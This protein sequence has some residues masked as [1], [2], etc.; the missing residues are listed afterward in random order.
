MRDTGYMVHDSRYRIH[1]ARSENPKFEYRHPK[2]FGQLTILSQVEG[3]I[4][5]SNVLNNP[6]PQPSPRR[7]EEARMI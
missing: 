3:Q 5:I 6:S 7:G 2:W 1:D 4:Q